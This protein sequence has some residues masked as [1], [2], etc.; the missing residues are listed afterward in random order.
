[1]IE[2]PMAQQVIDQTTIQPN[3]KKGEPATTAFDKINKNFTELYSDL[4]ASKGANE[5]ITSLTG[6]TTP[7]SIAQ[8][9]TGANSA[10]GALRSLGCAS[11]GANGD[12]TSL[13]GLSTPLSIGQGGTGANSAT[14][15]MRALGGVSIGVENGSSGTTLSSGGL[16]AFHAAGDSRVGALLIGNQSNPGAVASISFIREGAFGAHFGLD[17]TNEFCVGGWSMGDRSCRIYHSGN[18]TRA[19]DGTLRAI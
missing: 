19:A 1:L 3:G 14:G 7:L 8:G 17:I 9:G 2:V 6:L 15:A 4:F 12:I 10:A 11:N 16:P 13:S 5:D 18:T